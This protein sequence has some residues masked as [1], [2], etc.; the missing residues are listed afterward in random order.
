M[1][2]TRDALSFGARLDAHEALDLP[3]EF[4]LRIE[5][6]AREHPISWRSGDEVGVAVV[7]LATNDG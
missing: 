6:M 2:A 3:Q 1:C 4:S 5:S 7:D